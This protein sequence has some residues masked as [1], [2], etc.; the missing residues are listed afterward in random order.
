MEPVRSRPQRPASIERPGTIDIAGERV[1]F[2]ICYEQLL[3]LPVLHIGNRTADA[4]RR[5]GEP[6]L[7]SRNKHSRSATGLLD[8]LVST[9]R[10][11]SFIAENK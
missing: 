8:G 10:A 9:F 2:L 5:H 6:V 7:G 11:A 3:V 1:A 4:D